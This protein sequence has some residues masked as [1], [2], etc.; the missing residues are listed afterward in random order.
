VQEGGFEGREEG[1]VHWPHIREVLQRRELA[2]VEAVE[3]APKIAELFGGECA[4]DPGKTGIGEIGEGEATRGAHRGNA[5]EESENLG[6]GEPC[7]G[8]NRLRIKLE[9]TTPARV[10]VDQK[11]LFPKGTDIAD[12]GTPR[13]ANLD[14]EGIDGHMSLSAQTADQGVL[15]EADV[16]GASLADLVPDFGTIRV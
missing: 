3:Q 6:H 14:R 16:H 13:G 2:Y 4:F 8:L 1:G 15:A 12:D 10:S 11:S 5:E 7:G 9:T